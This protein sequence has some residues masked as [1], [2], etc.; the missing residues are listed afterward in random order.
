MKLNLIS[1]LVLAAA[2]A[3]PRVFGDKA[4]KEASVIDKDFDPTGRNKGEL[5]TEFSD[6]F[7]AIVVDEHIP[8][9]KSGDIVKGV[10][11]GAGLGYYMKCHF[12]KPAP[13]ATERFVSREIKSDDVIDLRARLA[14]AEA[15]L[16]KGGDDAAKARITALETE[17]ADLK[18]K[19]A[20]SGTEGGE[21]ENILKARSEFVDEVW[22]ALCGDSKMPE[23]LDA[24][25]KL[26]AAKRVFVE[27][28]KL[29]PPP[30]T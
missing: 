16:A 15:K 10:E 24:D 22:T 7:V 26:K 17:V 23:G 30:S 21:D 14:D 12:V 6:Q 2:L 5:T 13:G 19:A 11:L 4:T 3:S 25:G 28:G 18:K 20:E 1:A 27:L 8:G 29:K 9:F